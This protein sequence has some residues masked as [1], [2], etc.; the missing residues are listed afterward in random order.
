MVTILGMATISC[1]TSD[2]LEDVIIQDT[3]TS[4]STDDED[5]ENPKPGSN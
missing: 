3:S 5:K 2:N 4:S 1:D